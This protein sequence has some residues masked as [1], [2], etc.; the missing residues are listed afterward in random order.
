MPRIPLS[1]E[2]CFLKHYFRIY[3]WIQD[4]YQRL[5]ALARLKPLAVPAKEPIIPILKYDEV[6]KEEGLAQPKIR[7][8]PP[9][10][11]YTPYYDRQRDLNR[12][13]FKDLR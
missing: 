9:S 12:P 7:V 1:Q 4:H 3:V 8:R 5:I 13:F 10:R 6:L 11:C 2:E